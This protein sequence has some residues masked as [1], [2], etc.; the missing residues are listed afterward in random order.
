MCGI[1]SSLYNR[2]IV[3]PH[4]LNSYNQGSQSEKTGYDLLRC[5]LKAQLLSQ[6]IK[7]S[8]TDR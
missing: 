6:I 8:D 2:N 5:T 3:W 4:S 7:H 1:S